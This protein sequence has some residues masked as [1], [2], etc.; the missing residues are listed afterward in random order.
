MS[1]RQIAWNIQT[2]IDF[3][4]KDKQKNCQK[5]EKKPRTLRDK[6]IEKVIVV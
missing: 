3:H 5:S 6:L 1:F 4:F 2:L